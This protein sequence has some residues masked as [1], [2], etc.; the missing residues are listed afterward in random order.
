MD[1]PRQQVS[2]TTGRSKWKRYRRTGVILAAVKAGGQ[3]IILS[4]GFWNPLKTLSV[5]GD[6]AV[7][8]AG[9]SPQRALPAKQESLS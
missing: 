6:E 5:A 3:S 4:Q 1:W 7:R 9:A 8:D 2:Q